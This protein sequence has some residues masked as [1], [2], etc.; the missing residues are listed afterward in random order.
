[1]LRAMTATLAAQT[2][3]GGQMTT[4]TIW[5]IKRDGMPYVAGVCATRMEAENAVLAAMHR[6]TGC[7]A[8]HAFKHEGYQ[9]HYESRAVKHTYG[10]DWEAQKW[11]EHFEKYDN[12]AHRISIPGLRSVVPVSRQAIVEALA[13]GD[14]HLNTIPLQ[15][16]DICHL[17][18]QA[19]LRG[20]G[21]KSW[22][23]GDTVCVVKHVAK[24]H[25]APRRI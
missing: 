17:A 2:G 13:S 24:H 15:K 16:W 10:E 18:V 23:L 14:E 21:V 19:M 9:A 6:I 25:M 5:T 12:L 22:S 4:L 1:V 11:R 7:S 20:T 3:E 8:A